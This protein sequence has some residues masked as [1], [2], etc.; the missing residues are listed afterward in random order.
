MKDNIYLRMFYKVSKSKA[1]TFL[2]ISKLYIVVTNKLNI[3]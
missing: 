3:D 2:V 1:A